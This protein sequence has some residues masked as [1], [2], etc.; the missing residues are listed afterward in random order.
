MRFAKTGFMACA[1]IPVRVP[2]GCRLPHE[3]ARGAACDPRYIGQT[4]EIGPVAGT[5]RGRLPPTRRISGDCGPTLVTR[6]APFSMLPVGTQAMNPVSRVAV[7]LRLLFVLR[8][9]D[10][11]PGDRLGFRPADGQEQVPDDTGRG[12]RVRL[13]DPDPTVVRDRREVLGRG[14]DLRRAALSA[15]G[16]SR[17]RGRAR[18]VPWDRGPRSAAWAGDPRE[19][20]P[21]AL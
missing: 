1:A 6:S 4:H 8:H 7:E 14:L 10:D 17:S 9:F 16:R 11:A 5:T 15:D 12:Y 18:Q 13:N 3:V 19:T 2:C 21:T 20:S